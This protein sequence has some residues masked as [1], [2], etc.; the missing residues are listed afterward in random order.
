MFRPVTWWDSE[1]PV[2]S[3]DTKWTGWVWLPPPGPLEEKK[4]WI[5]VNDTHTYYSLK[6]SEGGLSGPVLQAQ[7]NN[8]T[9]PFFMKS[10]VIGMPFIKRQIGHGDY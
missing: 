7:Y 5:R 10:R 9:G 2:S 6:W 3:N 1:I 8:N 4:E